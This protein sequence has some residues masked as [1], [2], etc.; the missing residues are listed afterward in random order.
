[1]M[2]Q[3]PAYA[4]SICIFAFNRFGD[5]GFCEECN[6]QADIAYTVDVTDFL[7]KL[8]LRNKKETLDSIDV[9]VVIRDVDGQ[10]I[11]IAANF[12]KPFPKADLLWENEFFADSIDFG[13][14]TDTSKRDV[15]RVRAFLEYYGYSAGAGSKNLN[16]ALKKFQTAYGLEA[17]GILGPV[18]QAFVSRPRSANSDHKDDCPAIL[19]NKLR[20]DRYKILYTVTD[21]DDDLVDVNA[22]DLGL[23]RLVVVLQ[24]AF[25]AWAKPLG[26]KI[27]HVIHFEYVE[28]D[29]KNIDLEITWVTFDGI[30]GT[31][32]YADGHRGKVAKCSIQLDRSERWTLDNN[33]PY[34]VQPVITHEVGHL[35]GLHH[36][37]DESTI[38]FPYYRN[39]FVTVPAKDIEAV[40]KRAM[41]KIQPKKK[42]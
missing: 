42:Q 25:Q 35:F 32:G 12:K 40:A 30:G 1:M 28:P 38:M 26:E 16:D 17:D 3:D 7:D 5:D 4:G 8:G 13:K 11:D 27:G 10:D 18:T 36:E 21:V 39:D 24:A 34:S 33:L 41:D 29:H 23:H 20:K 6:K 19:L 2:L 37:N 15:Q 9:E 14:I 31:L 22:A